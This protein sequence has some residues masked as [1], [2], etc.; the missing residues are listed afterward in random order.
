MTD[1]VRSTGW[2]RVLVTGSRYWNEYDPVL[3]TF[4]SIAGQHPGQRFMLIDGK[5]D[6]RSPLANHPRIPWDAADMWPRARKLELL[7]ADWL[8]HLAAQALGWGVEL[9]PADW[10]KGDAAGRDRNTYVTGLDI[11]EAVACCGPCRSPRC[12]RPGWHMSHGTAHC[13]REIAKAGIPF[14]PLRSST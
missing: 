11:D 2:R 14:T 8:A 5:C 4:T 9:Y 1:Q 12:R 6:P 10:G 13:L 3:A 7:G